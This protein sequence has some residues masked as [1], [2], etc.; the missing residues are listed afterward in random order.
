V[1][2]EMLLVATIAAGAGGLVLLLA[3]LAAVGRRVVRQSAPILLLFGGPSLV[4]VVLFPGFIDRFLPALLPAASFALLLAGPARGRP[5]HYRSDRRR[6]YSC[7]L[8]CLLGARLSGA[9][10][11][12][13]AGRDGTRRARDS[14]GGDRRRLR[15]ERLVPRR[16]GHP[17]GAA[18]VARGQ[19]GAAT[20]K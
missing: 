12:A 4:P 9:P 2:E 16:S 18:A 3:G 15:V 13:V 10:P 19:N 20:P 14:A 11:G 1:S 5:P 8:E 17:G 7:A 6:W